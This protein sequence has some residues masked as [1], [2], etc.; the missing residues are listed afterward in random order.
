MELFKDAANEA[1][2]KKLLEVGGREMAHKDEWQ[3]GEKMCLSVEDRFFAFRDEETLNRFDR[4]V[5]EELRFIIDQYA[6]REF[7]L[8]LR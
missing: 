6:R 2:R 4:F 3:E 7:Y 5:V 1:I 8:R